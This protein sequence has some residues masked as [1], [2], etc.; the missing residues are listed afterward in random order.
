MAINLVDKKDFTAEQLKRSDVDG[1][2]KVTLTD[3][4]TI[5]QFVSKKID[6]LGPQ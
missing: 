4:A 1:D 6:K 3:L 5:R 2:G